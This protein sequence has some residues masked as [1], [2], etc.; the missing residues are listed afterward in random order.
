MNETKPF[1]YHDQ[2]VLPRGFR[3]GGTCCGLKETENDLALFLSD[4]PAD[5]AAVFTRSHFAGA[6]VVR[7]RRVIKRGR[8][9][10]VVVNSKISNVGTGETGLQNA[11]RMAQSVAAAFAVEN[12]DVLAASTGVIGRQLPIER[13]ERGVSSLTSSL[14]RDPLPAA[15][16]MMTTDTHPKAFSLSLG[17]ATLTIAAK[18]VGMVEPNMATMLAFIF[19]DAALNREVLDSALRRAVH[20][21]FNMLSVDTDTSTSDMCAVMANGQAGPVDPPRFEAA[22]T[23]LCIRMAKTLA[24]DGEGATKLL[25]ARVEGA[26]DEEEARV[27][28]KAVINSP[29]IKTMAYGGDPNIGR[30]LMA[31][32]KCLTCHVRPERVVIHINERRVFAESA[33]ADFDDSEV[34]RLLG[35]DHV[36]IGV[37]LGLGEGRAEAY[38]CDLSEG[39]IR[40][41]AA[42]TSS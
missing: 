33:P 34:R 16:G 21:S 19:T 9:R 4:H 23:A 25:E 42:Y 29:L 40:E 15:A 38:G 28:A 24:R 3:C 5:A 7:G 39:Y 13:I 1:L 20:V 41:N 27:I 11:D 2:P 14:G 35:G 31:L 36:I 30:L 12:G 32:G 10:A 8:L 17:D 26:F 37:D 18:G 22:L 6:P